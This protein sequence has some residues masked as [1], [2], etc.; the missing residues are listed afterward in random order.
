MNKLMGEGTFVVALAGVLL[1]A[2]E[3]RAILIESTPN[4]FRYEL[5]INPDATTDPADIAGLFAL[6][7]GANPYWSMEDLTIVGQHWP[8]PAFAMGFDL[9][10]ITYGERNVAETPGFGGVVGQGFIEFGSPVGTSVA[11]N[12]D[13]LLQETLV[14]GA[15]YAFDALGS[16][17]IRIHASRTPVS[18]GGSSA[19]FLILGLAGCRALAHRLGKPPGSRLPGHSR[20]HI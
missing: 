5:G 7:S 13:V 11:G 1:V 2:S 8:Q 4:R 18:S 3:A 14:F 17:V 16:G 12:F 20:G 9:L 19:L 15:D 10:N 6:A